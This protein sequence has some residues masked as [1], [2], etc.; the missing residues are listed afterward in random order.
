MTRSISRIRTSR[1]FRTGERGFVLI[2]ALVIA[3]LYFSLIEL[4]LLDSSRRLEAAQRFRSRIAARILAE[5]GAELAAQ[6]MVHA[7]S[8]SGEAELAAGVLEGK[9]ERSADS[10]VLR[11]R[12]RTGGVQQASA[13]IEIVGRIEGQLVR[14]DSSRQIP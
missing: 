6:N 3:A 4:T 14:I 7:A 9:F 12:G 10:F 1:R 5:N 13:G 2:S 11:G 8:T